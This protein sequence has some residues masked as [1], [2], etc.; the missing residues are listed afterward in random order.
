M[1]YYI[2]KT[3]LIKQQNTKMINKETRTI[4]YTL[5]RQH[6]VQKLH[7]LPAPIENKLL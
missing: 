4:I 7:K 2:K 3:N 5:C 1:K 6:S